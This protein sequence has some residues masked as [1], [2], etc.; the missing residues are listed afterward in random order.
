[1]F[2]L[3]LGECNQ[4][5]K[6]YGEG[7][8]WLKF[9][10]KLLGCFWGRGRLINDLSEV[11]VHDLTFMKT[12]VWN[13]P[14]RSIHGRSNPAY[15]IVEYGTY[16][17]DEVFY[18]N[19]VSKHEHRHRLIWEDYGLDSADSEQ[20]PNAG[21]CESD[22]GPDGSIKLVEFF[23]TWSNVNLK[24]LP[25]R[26]RCGARQSQRDRPVVHTC[27]D[28]YTSP[29]NFFGIINPLTPELNPSAQLWLTRFFTGDFASWTV[30]FVN[31]C[32]KN[33]QRHQLFIQ[34][35]NYVW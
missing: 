32:V 8:G 28:S 21:F 9:K 3:G 11:T 33:Q 25:R 34:F 27:K 14:T 17:E 20:D 10:H 24:E 16:G 23:T 1:M 30:N 29:F 31:I 35:I 5:H 12:F 18:K 2:H 13:K 7:G 22:N 15:W 19:V 26:V 6:R 4:R